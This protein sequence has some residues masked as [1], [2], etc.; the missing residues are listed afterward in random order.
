MTGFCSKALPKY[1]ELVQQRQRKETLRRVYI[2]PNE[3]VIKQYIVNHSRWPFYA[4]PWLREEKAMVRAKAT[5][6]VPKHIDTIVER[7]NTTTLCVTQIK[8][9]VE[10]EP[11][12]IADQLDVIAVA[13]LLAEL[14]SVKV[15]TNDCQKEN[16]L[17]NNTNKLQC[18]DLGR[19]STYRY[20]SLMY[21]RAIGSE[22]A[23]LFRRV[24]D[25]N[26]CLMQVFLKRYFQIIG[27][28]RWQKSLVLFFYHLSH[29]A[30]LKRRIKKT[31]ERSNNK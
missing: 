14:H 24:L 30:R 21:Y 12:T 18:I 4:K 15:I 23:R 29:S 20:R 9:F 16:M 1:A 25:S 2:V 28:S 7:I 31:K 27:F 22:M 26:E 17:R 3:K 5:H 8:T 19:A 6:R 10:G 11:L 13:E